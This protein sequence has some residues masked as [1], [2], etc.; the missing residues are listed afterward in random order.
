MTSP[1]VTTVTISHSG[2]TVETILA[3][4]LALSSATAD[5]PIAEPHRDATW[6]TRGL[7]TE[8]LP[9]PD[10]DGQPS[11]WPLASLTY[12]NLLD[13]FTEPVAERSYNRSV[14]EAFVAAAI[15]AAQSETG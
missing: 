1:E 3:T 12:L 13:S 4:R 7:L 10:I 2:S 15:A 6:T 8:D 5:N 14:I 11:T 9:G